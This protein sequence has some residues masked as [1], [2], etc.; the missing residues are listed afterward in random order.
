MP[1]K[2]GTGP[3]GFGSKTGRGYGHCERAVK[4][5]HGKS[6]G[7]RMGF[8]CKHGFSHRLGRNFEWDMFSPET[9]KKLL[10]KQKELFQIRIGAIDKQLENL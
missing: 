3:I 9:K 7:R 5:G 10:Q 4:I 6:S 2:D 8:G 1:G